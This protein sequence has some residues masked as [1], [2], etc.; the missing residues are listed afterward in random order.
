MNE[1]NL[2]ERGRL[3]KVKENI[4][5][6]RYHLRRERERSSVERKSAS[7]E[8]NLDSEGSVEL[9]CTVSA[10]LERMHVSNLS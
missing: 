10:N 1:G 8:N 7:V 2:C 9:V 5:T 6:P 3:R 4:C